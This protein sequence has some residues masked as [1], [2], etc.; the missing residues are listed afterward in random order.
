MPNR[1]APVV[2]VGGFAGL[3]AARELH[4]RSIPVVVYEAGKQVA[5]LARTFRDE[6]G[7]TYDFGAH[8]ITNRLA[9]EVGV[10]AQCRTV[11]YYGESV[12]TDGQVYS[13]PFG[14]VRS[15]RFLLGALTSY[16]AEALHGGSPTP[17]QPG[18][19]PTMAPPSPKRLPSPWSKRGQERGLR[20][21]RRRSG[22]SWR[23]ASA[24]R[25]F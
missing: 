17:L 10:A 7:F 23:A 3:V 8:F 1:H 25:S 18:S 21:G 24:T 13:Y 12:V 9:A 16:A 2:I 14:L 22:T 11:R 15:P 19:E 5:G 4:R 20:I 6:E